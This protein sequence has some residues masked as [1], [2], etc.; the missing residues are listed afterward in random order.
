MA[1]ETASE[2]EIERAVSKLT[3]MEESVVTDKMKKAAREHCRALLDTWAE[4]AREHPV[5]HWKCKDLFQ[6][7]NSCTN[8]FTTE[9]RFAQMKRTY[10]IEKLVRRQNA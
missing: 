7:A 6:V 10:A 3:K 5:L 8:D 9:E 1:S 2:A 4:C